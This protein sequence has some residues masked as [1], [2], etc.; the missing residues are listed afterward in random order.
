[1]QFFRKFQYN[2][3]KYGLL[4]KVTKNLGDSGAEI[5]SFVVFYQRYPPSYPQFCAITAILLLTEQLTRCFV[6]QN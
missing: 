2:P 1:M 4:R 3:Y 5:T 6:V